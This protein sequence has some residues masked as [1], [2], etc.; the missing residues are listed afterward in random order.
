MG[1]KNCILHMQSLLFEAFYKL[2]FESLFEYIKILLVLPPIRRKFDLDYL[3]SVQI[4]GHAMLIYKSM[5]QWKL[6]MLMAIHVAFQLLIFWRL[7]GG[8]KI[9]NSRVKGSK[10]PHLVPVSEFLVT[11][12]FLL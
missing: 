9:G 11:F 12:C 5:S 10:L 4:F 6:M 1:S 2:K 8:E 3:G 7:K